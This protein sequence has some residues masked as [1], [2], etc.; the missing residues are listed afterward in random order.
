M[1]PKD[2][3]ISQSCSPDTT[4]SQRGSPL[5][6]FRP[7]PRRRPSQGRRRGVSDGSSPP[8]DRSPAEVSER[9]MSSRGRGS[10]VSGSSLPAM[11]A[12]V[13]AGEC[14][15]T[16]HPAP[17][18]SGWADRRTGGAAGRPASLVRC[19]P[20]GSCRPDGRDRCA[21]AR[22]RVGG[23]ATVAGAVTCPGPIRQ[24]SEP[25]PN[26]PASPGTPRAGSGANMTQ[27]SRPALQRCR[28]PTNAPNSLRS[29]PGD[30][31]TGD[32]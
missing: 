6:C 7:R 30:S 4:W 9:S 13:A 23:A 32:G 2:A 17:W 25:G 18:P 22:C 10:P 31:P 8:V 28:P 19:R 16:G 3:G 27:N 11:S 20:G 15:P 1:A 21:C 26:G 12:G 14:L 29:R 24:T 5:R